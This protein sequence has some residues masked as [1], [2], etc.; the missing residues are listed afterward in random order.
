[1]I[2]V[3]ETIAIVVFL[4]IMMYIEIKDSK[5]IKIKARTNYVRMGMAIVIS[6]SSA[7]IFWPNNLPQQLELLTISTLILFFGFV[8][9]GLGRE[10]VIKVGTLD[11]DYNRYE[12]IELESEDKKNRFTRVSFFIRKNNA[13]SLVVT[14]DKNKVFDYLNQAI[15]DSDKVQFR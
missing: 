10:Q 11:G 15:S 3:N 13:T 2:I 8:P 1:M 5:K 6:I 14:G 12:K 9:E 7:V 4:L